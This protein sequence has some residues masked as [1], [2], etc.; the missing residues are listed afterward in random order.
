[1]ALILWGG[2]KKINSNDPCIGNHVRCGSQG[3]PF[4]LYG[5][6][7]VLV[8]GC[9][10]LWRIQSSAQGGY[11]GVSALEVGGETFQIFAAN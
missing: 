11:G 6:G 9:F 2:S 4:E 5:C 10:L 3:V 1:M 8:Y 7:M